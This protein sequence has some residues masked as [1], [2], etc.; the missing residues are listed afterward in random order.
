MVFLVVLCFRGSDKL[1]C[2]LY[3]SRTGRRERKK[4]T[5]KVAVAI[6]IYPPFQ[7]QV[8]GLYSHRDAVREETDSLEAVRLIQLWVSDTYTGAFE[9]VYL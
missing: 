1:G 3:S 8:T 2:V 4:S 7:E 5:E 6:F 9:G